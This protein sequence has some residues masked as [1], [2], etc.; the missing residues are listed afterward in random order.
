M[1]KTDRWD[2]FQGLE[3][4]IS[5]TIV[6]AFTCSFHLRGIISKISKRVSDYKKAKRV[7]NT[8]N[9]TLRSHL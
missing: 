2:G 5:I 8:I 4:I 7:E 9:R 6:R 3:S 1:G